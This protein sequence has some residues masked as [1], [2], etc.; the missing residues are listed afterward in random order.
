[1]NKKISGLISALVLSA[2]VGADAA[3]MKMSFAPIGSPVM[4]KNGAM[5][6]TV[7]GSELIPLAGRTFSAAK[8][9]SPAAGR[10]ALIIN[11][12]YMDK[13]PVE[14][15]EL[16]RNIFTD[17]GSTAAYYA[18]L[19]AP[20][21]P[22]PENDGVADGVITVR[23]PGTTPYLY[24]A[25]AVQIAQEIV[26]EASKT[27]DFSTLDTNHDGKVMYDEAV[28]ACL[29][30]SDSIAAYGG[31]F[32]T[33]TNWVQ[34]NGC[35]INSIAI[36]ASPVDRDWFPYGQSATAHE[37]GHALYGF[38]DV[39]SVSQ[40][41]AG[42]RSWSLMGA[43]FPT[44]SCRPDPFNLTKFGFVTPRIVTSSA[45]VQALGEIGKIE[46]GDP[47]VYQLVELR[48]IS[49]FDSLAGEHLG[50]NIPG[51]RYCVTY[52]VNESFANNET[53]GLINVAE[54]S[55]LNSAT[56]TTTPTVAP[57]GNPGGETGGGGGGGCNT[58][59]GSAALL[60]IPAMLMMRRR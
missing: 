59:I 34:A 21:S 25:N 24:Q 60:L 10:R 1:M 14:N 50:M 27:F 16:A 53:G 48:E 32:G 51:N 18:A 41:S 29:F 7:R 31:G 44:A 20:L 45:D 38:V 58:G 2:A 23:M 13:T 3:P 22:A 47:N 17:P 39:Y 42:L 8:A 9:T 37:F 33:E 12:I 15:E 57:T 4:G 11:A 35:S 49:G 40:E 26:A 28:V 54:I 30:V 19:G 55:V 52:N 5:V 36:E 6:A 56:P 46:T 43:W